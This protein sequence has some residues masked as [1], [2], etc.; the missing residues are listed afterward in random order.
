MFGPFYMYLRLL[1]RF[2]PITPPIRDESIII[3]KRKSVLM[4]KSELLAIKDTSIKRMNI[5]IP[6]AP[7]IKSPFFPTFFDRYIEEKSVPTAA[8]IVA[9]RG[10]KLYPP[11]IKYITIANIKIPTKVTKS[12]IKNAVK[13]LR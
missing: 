2:T 9:K 10:E 4:L 11:S 3:I 1:L 6:T 8:D 5:I 13:I 7:P 12:Q